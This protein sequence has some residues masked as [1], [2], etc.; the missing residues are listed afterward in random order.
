[1]HRD[2][3]PKN[4]NTAADASACVYR[5]CDMPERLRPRE[6]MER[7]GAEYVTDDVLLAVILR[8]GTRGKNVVELARAL[9][10]KYGSLTALAKAPLGE[11]TQI[12]GIKD[13]KALSLQAALEIAKRL[14]EESIG[15]NQSIRSPE[16]AARLLREPARTMDQETFWVLLL[17]AKNRLK[18]PPLDVTKGLVNA[19]LVHPREVFQGAIR[20]ACAA[21]ILAH[22]H[23]S[24]DFTPSAEDIRITKQMVEAGRIVDIRVLDHV[25]VGRPTP[26]SARD[27]LSMREA[28]VVEFPA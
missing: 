2:M 22:N 18:S 23:P 17:D 27:F 8:S 5:V 14:S 10:L 1:M 6:V 26:E 28:G 25:I 12:P 16:D 19:S 7:V 21:V 20:S 13:A 4:S 24:G 3:T 15:Q 9:L 11:L